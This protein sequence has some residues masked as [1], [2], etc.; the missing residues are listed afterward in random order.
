M[1][2]SRRTSI[3][4]RP[5]LE[6]GLPTAAVGRSSQATPARRR[7]QACSGVIRTET[8]AFGAVLPTPGDFIA[9]V[10]NTVGCSFI[11]AG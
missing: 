1:I 4:D 5:S 2:A 10:D 11:V 8:I 7:G 9:G 3:P 6:H